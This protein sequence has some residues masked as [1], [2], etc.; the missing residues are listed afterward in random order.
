[1]DQ[2]ENCPVTPET[3][4]PLM[5]L[6]P[7]PTLLVSGDGEVV[8]VNRAVGEWV[9]IRSS[10]MVGRKLTD[11]VADSEE[12][13]NR[14]LRNC[15]RSG[16]LVLGTLTFR[17]IHEHEP[18]TAFRCQGASIRP[19][20]SEGRAQVLI[21]LTPR[22][23][24]VERFVALNQK[25]AALSDE[26][27]KV[28]RVEKQLSDANQRIR[29]IL[30]ATG[31]G[32]WFSKPPLPI[33]DWDEKMHEL[34]FVPLGEQ[35]TM[36]LFLERLHPA[37]R[38]STREAI[39]AAFR[40]GKVFELESRVCDPANGK[41][42]WLLTRGVA[43]TS[44]NET[45]LDAISYD[46]S[47]R[48]GN[49]AELMKI[50]AELSEENRKKSEFLATLAHELRNPLAPIRTGLEILKMADGNPSVG[51]QTREMMER[52]VI[53]LT[54]LIDDLMD[55]SR[56]SRGKLTLNC[57][58]VELT[59]I[60]QSAQEAAIPLIHEGGHTLEIH[61]PDEPVYL[62]ADPHRLAQVFS[63]LLINAAK[64]THRGGMIR[65]IAIRSAGRLS[66]SV[67]DN[68]I[69][70]AEE[71]QAQIFEMFA[72]I[73]RATRKGYAGLGIGLTLVKSLVELHGGEIT[74]TSEGEGCG[75]KFTVSLPSPEPQ[76]EENRTGDEADSPEQRASSVSGRVL[77][78]DDNPE[79]VEALAVMLQMM[80][81]QTRSAYDGKE[82]VREA[83]NF[84]PEVILMDLGMPVM[85][86]YEAARRIRERSGGRSIRMI[87]VSGWGT[88]EVRKRAADAGFDHHLIKPADPGV[89]RGLISG[90]TA[91]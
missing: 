72:Q 15:G 50:A 90:K 83:E 30:E 54:V 80:G 69:G 39:A 34:M 13:V 91:D 18:T 66:V 86:G 76:P 73:D 31:V 11:L 8:A 57:S 7:E 81:Y 75:A 21:R 44:G 58:S 26:I 45:H 71:V 28:R 33:L 85:N 6:L 40:D 84:H 43:S 64:F 47:E 61:L 2:N 42:H 10:H 53:Q 68:G 36:E 52:Q 63:N 16:S 38:E 12:T 24:A 32:R 60:I 9:A 78:V 88:D 62:N 23:V 87:A 70:I 27:A 41:I 37:D 82:A 55:V 56:V 65:L 3:F 25:I 67:E 51:R 35:P 22:Q 49:E 1:M 46:I 77:I 74:V 48:K 29:F 17:T 4:H 59:S 5:D 79:A 19:A 89:L 14:Y 20:D